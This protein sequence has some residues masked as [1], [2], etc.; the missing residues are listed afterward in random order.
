[1]DK[2]DELLLQT[3]CDERGLKD[4]T[5]KSYT[6]AIGLYCRY[7]KM[8]FHELLDE[9]EQEERDDVKWKRSKL[10]ARL[11]GFRNDLQQK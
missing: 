8:P 2:K 7:N 6:T 1:M 5:K 10:R 3:F 9:A 11:L 4:V